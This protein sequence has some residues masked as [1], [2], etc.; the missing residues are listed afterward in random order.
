[1]VASRAE[2]F[3]G[4]GSR[5]PKGQRGNEPASSMGL[6]GSFPLG[7][8][9]LLAASMPGPPATSGNG[10]PNGGFKWSGTVV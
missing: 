5:W 8:I 9:E 7:S 10:H 1:M 2:V 3:C 6:S 4:S